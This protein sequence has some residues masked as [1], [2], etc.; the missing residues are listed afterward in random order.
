LVADGRFDYLPKPVIAVLVGG[1]H[2][3]GDFTTEDAND[4]ARFLNS[5]NASVLLTTSRRTEIMVAQKFKEKIDNL[6]FYK[7]ISHKK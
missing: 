5:K 3:G 2:V 6:S 7:E 4:L 1:K